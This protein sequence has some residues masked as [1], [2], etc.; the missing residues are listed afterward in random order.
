MAKDVT[1][2]LKRRIKSMNRHL[3]NLDIEERE[4]EN[5]GLLFFKDNFKD[6][7]QSIR[8][9]IAGIETEIKKEG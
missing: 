7:R 1:E 2:K 9:I 3:N 5:Q 6:L 8:I 4:L